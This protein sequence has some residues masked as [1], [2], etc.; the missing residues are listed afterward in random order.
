[1]P[2]RKPKASITL[3][4]ISEEFDASLMKVD[5]LRDNLL[6]EVT[7]MNNLPQNIMVSSSECLRVVSNNCYLEYFLLLHVICPHLL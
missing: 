1:M 7:L 6:G 3:S 4:P 2:I 5:A